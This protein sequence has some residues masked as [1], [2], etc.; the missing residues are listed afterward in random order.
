MELVFEH[1]NEIAVVK[2]KSNDVTFATL[3][4]GV[5]HFVPIDNI[6]LSPSGI[7][8]QFPDLVNMP[9]PQMKEEAKKRF[10]THVK[11]LLEL[12][13]EDRIKKYIVNE[14]HFHGYKLIR[15]RKEGWREQRVK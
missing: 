15:I 3:T 12:G 4:A 1:G 10:K 8:N 5:N 2:I 6:K 14:L 13:G 11:E 9:I 7:V